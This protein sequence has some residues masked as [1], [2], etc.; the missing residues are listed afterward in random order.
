MDEPTM[1][2]IMTQYHV[3]KGLKVFGKE[4]MEA[5]LNG[6]QQLHDRMVMNP[7]KPEDTMKKE[8]KESLQYLMFLKKK[9]RG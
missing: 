8:K 5:V 4:G 6:L 3:S 7:K 9:R 1:H 2:L